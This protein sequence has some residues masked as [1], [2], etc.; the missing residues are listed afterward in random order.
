MVSLHTQ[1]RKASDKISDIDA[2]IPK[3]YRFVESVISYNNTAI[4]AEKVKWD[5]E[6]LFEW[7]G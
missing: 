3:L 7:K 5:Q 2:Y 1:N 4:E 6:L